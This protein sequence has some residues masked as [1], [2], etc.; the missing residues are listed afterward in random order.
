VIH[1]TVNVQVYSNRVNHLH[2][3]GDNGQGVFWATSGMIGTD[4]NGQGPYDSASSNV[5]NFNNYH[6][7]N[8]GDPRADPTETAIMRR[9]GDKS[10]LLVP[11]VYQG[12]SVTF[13]PST[14]TPPP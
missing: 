7:I 12:R 5:F 11:L 1:S 3:A 14:V 9:F 8:I 13:T 2:R 10:L 4:Q 6:V